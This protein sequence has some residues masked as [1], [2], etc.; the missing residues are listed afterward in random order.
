MVF[1]LKQ[2]RFSSTMEK[3]DKPLRILVCVKQVLSQDGPIEIDPSGRSLF[4]GKIP[5]Y[6]L[7]RFDE[8]ALEEALRVKD[9]FPDTNLHAMTVG[10]AR[11]EAV[12]RRALS[13][14]VDHGVHLLT[15]EGEEPTPFQISSWIAARSDITHTT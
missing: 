9:A 3:M 6:V 15:E 8:F 11:A 4:A 12:I 1:C 10:P 14:G 5:L 7:N 13:M 2:P